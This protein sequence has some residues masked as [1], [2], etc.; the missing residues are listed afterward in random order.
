MLWICC[1]TSPQQIEQM[2]VEHYL[3]TVYIISFLLCALVSTY[4]IE[5]VSTNSPLNVHCYIKVLSYTYPLWFCVSTFY[6][7]PSYICLCVFMFLICFWYLCHIPYCLHLPHYNKVYFLTYFC[8]QRYK[9]VRIFG[10]LTLLWL[11]LPQKLTL[12]SFSTSSLQ[13]TPYRTA[14]QWQFFADRCYCHNVSSVW[15][16]SVSDASVLWQNGC[17]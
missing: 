3:T 2:E 15:R 5:S 12:P 10:R 8:F 4:D 9:I 1:T 16:L 11:S 17:S 6:M 13:Y 14:P 7:F